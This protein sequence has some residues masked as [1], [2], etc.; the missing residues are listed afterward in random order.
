LQR[1]GIAPNPELILP[2]N[3]LPAGHP[4]MRGERA[5]RRPLNRRFAMK[6][7]MATTAALTLLAG[8]STANAQNAPA[9]TNDKS[10]KAMEQSAAPKAE[11]RSNARHAR[12]KT[13]MTGHKASIDSKSTTGA[14]TIG[15]PRNDPSIHQSSGDRDSRDYPKSH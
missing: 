6:A 7:W 13:R 9:G 1:R 12:E 5:R 3:V 8:I 4:R 14:G 11:S 10:D 15:G 2:F